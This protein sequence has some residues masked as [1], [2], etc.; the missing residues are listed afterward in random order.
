VTASRP[1]E[2]LVELYR[3]TENMVGSVLFT[4][5]DWNPPDTSFARL[6]SSRPDLSPP[7]VIKQ[8]TVSDDWC[9]RCLERH[10]SY[11]GG[12]RSDIAATYGEWE[13]LL[14]AGCGTSMNVPLVGSDGQAVGIVNTFAGDQVY[15]QQSLSKFEQLIDRRQA[16]L[17]DVISRAGDDL[18]RS[19]SR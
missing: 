7:G 1:P 14:Q 18:R 6:F 10:E 16:E 8:G 15:D 17:T 19:L 3:Q 11:L 2:E 4:V 9:R 5:L 12:N 13:Q